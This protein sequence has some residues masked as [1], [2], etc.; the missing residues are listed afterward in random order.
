MF[1]FY[2]VSYAYYS[3]IYLPR[4][5]KT[6][7]ISLNHHIH[8]KTIELRY[9]RSYDF[10]KTDYITVYKHGVEHKINGTLVCHRWY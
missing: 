7:I 9:R 2:K 10:E 3:E 4:T 8:A 6:G 1:K 5:F